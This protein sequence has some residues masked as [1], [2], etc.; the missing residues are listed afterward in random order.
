MSYS[1][2]ISVDDFFL[3]FFFHYAL[4]ISPLLD[5]RNSMGMAFLPPSPMVM[6]AT[7]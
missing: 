4:K 6:V 5:L 1:F 7:N 3:T 2:S